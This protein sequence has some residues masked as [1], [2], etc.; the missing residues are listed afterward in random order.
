MSGIRKTVEK[1]VRRFLSQNNVHRIVAGK[2]ADENVAKHELVHKQFLDVIKAVTCGNIA[3]VGPAGVGKTTMAMQIADAMGL[4]F[5]FNG[6]INSEYKL[7]GFMDA[8]GRI[9][10][11]PFRK[12]FTEGG[13]YLFD[14]I[15][16]SMPSALLARSGGCICWL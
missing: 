2:V 10:S 11:T 1:E 6:A 7:S 3:L 8:Q 9:V 4:N 13:L 14:E 15:D 16:A 5:Y 12:A